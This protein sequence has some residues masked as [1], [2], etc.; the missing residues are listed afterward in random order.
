MLCVSLHTQ[1]NILAS[2]QIPAPHSGRFQSLNNAWKE[3]ELRFPKTTFIFG[4]LGF[5]ACV[6]VFGVRLPARHNLIHLNHT[7]I[8]IIIIIII[9]VSMAMPEILN[10][11]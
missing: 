2:R 4:N 5:V 1:S 6:Q 10:H 9:S 8:I 3:E 7:I 11:L